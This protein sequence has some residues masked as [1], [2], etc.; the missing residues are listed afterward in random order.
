MHGVSVKS[1]ESTALTK[2]WAVCDLLLWGNSVSGE[3]LSDGSGDIREPKVL[4]REVYSEREGPN[5]FEAIVCS[6]VSHINHISH[7]HHRA[8]IGCPHFVV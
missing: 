4:T 7:L 3:G 1:S 2:I 8:C 5:F 6:H